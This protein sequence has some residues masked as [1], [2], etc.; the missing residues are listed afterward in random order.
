MIL[1]VSFGCWL[2]GIEADALDQSP[3]IGAIWE[4]AVYGEL[5]RRTVALG[6]NRTFYYYHD[7]E[8]TEVDFLALGDGARFLEVKWTQYPSVKDGRNLKRLADLAKTGKS[9]ELQSPSLWV[10][11]RTDQGYPLGPDGDITVVG[12]DSVTEILTAKRGS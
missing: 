5:R 9:P 12:L 3:F 11:S 1:T 8:G 6:L 4:G 7:N 2:L 10:L